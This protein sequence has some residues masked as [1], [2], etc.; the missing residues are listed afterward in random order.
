MSASEP[1]AVFEEK[2]EPEAVC[3]YEILNG[4]PLGKS[5]ALGG[6]PAS[7]SLIGL[8]VELGSLENHREFDK[9]IG[10]T[11]RVTIEILD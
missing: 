7:D 6:D 5:V 1:Y 9:L 11:I 3:S 8:Y 2:I 10:K 4:K